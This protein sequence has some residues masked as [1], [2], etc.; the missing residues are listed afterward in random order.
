MADSPT[1]ILPNAVYTPE[2]VADLLQVGEGA[3]RNLLKA[4]SLR[5][6]TY[7]AKYRIFGQEVIRFCNE[8]SQ[9]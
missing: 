5:H 1:P 4:G 8:A 2:Q 3:I 7:S 6:M 9:P